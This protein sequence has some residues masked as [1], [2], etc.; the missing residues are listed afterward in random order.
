MSRQLIQLP[1]TMKALL[2]LGLILLSVTVQAKVYERCELARILK[3]NGMTGYSGVRLARYQGCVAKH[4]SGYN[5]QAIKYL[6]EAKARTMGY[7]KSTAD[8]GVMMAKPKEQRMFVKYTAVSLLQDDITQAIQCVK[9]V[10]NNPR[11][12]RT[13]MKLSTKCEY[14]DLSQYI[15]NCGVRPLCAS[16][17]ILSLTIGVGMGKVT[18]P[19]CP[20]ANRTS[21]ETGQDDFFLET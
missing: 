7:F 6:R 20:Q 21:A 14:D 13:W 11:S 16:T 2:T 4:E 19:P 18:L 17:D 15:R 10:V 9:R 5:T 8:T 3:K 12:I 1:V